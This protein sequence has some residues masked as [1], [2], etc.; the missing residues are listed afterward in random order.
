[1]PLER[2]PEVHHARAAMLA[3][4]FV[5]VA[6]TISHNTAEEACAATHAECSHLLGRRV[7]VKPLVCHPNVAELRKAILSPSLDHHAIVWQRLPGVAT[8]DG[9]CRA[10]LQRGDGL[11]GIYGPKCNEAC[12]GELAI[13]IYVAT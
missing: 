2:Y 1:M 9:R 10:D 6:S 13:V 4:L 11:H 12:R 3:I 7:A 5:R 8:L